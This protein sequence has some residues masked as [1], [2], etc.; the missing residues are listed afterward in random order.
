MWVIRLDGKVRGTDIEQENFQYACKGI[1]GSL[2]RW[3]K[4][5]FWAS[6]E[7]CPLPLNFLSLPCDEDVKSAK[8]Q[9]EGE[10]QT[11]EGEQRVPPR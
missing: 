8:G 9:G 7:T 5:A 6:L 1:F 4:K 11:Q 10:V 2:T 3:D